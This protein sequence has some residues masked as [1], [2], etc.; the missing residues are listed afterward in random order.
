MSEKLNIFAITL[1]R[2]MN[3]LVY[4][5]PCMLGCFL[6]EIV[7][8][9]FILILFVSL[10]TYCNKLYFRATRLRFQTKV[11]SQERVPKVVIQMEA[12]DVRNSESDEPLDRMDT[13]QVTKPK[14][15]MLSERICSTLDY[16][17]VVCILR[18]YC[19]T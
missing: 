16:S 4:H 13:G 5:I 2:E 14:S 10:V 8:I 9:Q 3:T 18:T 7:Q 6:R 17:V 15:A 19:N 1:Q 11:R 12:R